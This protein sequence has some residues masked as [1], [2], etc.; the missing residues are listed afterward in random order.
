MKLVITIDLDNAAMGSRLEVKRLLMK[1]AENYH[2]RSSQDDGKLM[3]VNG[4]T[5]GGWEVRDYVELTAD[6]VLSVKDR[7]SRSGYSAA[8]AL[9]CGNGERRGYDDR[10]VRVLAEVRS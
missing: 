4:N 3:D 6:E 10:K 8:Q 2:G 1:V 7:L 5:V 9:I